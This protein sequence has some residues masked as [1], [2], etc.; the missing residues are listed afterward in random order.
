M[1]AAGR[2]RLCLVTAVFV[3]LLTVAPAVSAQPIDPI[4][5]YAADVDAEAGL[6]ARAPSTSGAGGHK[7]TTPDTGWDAIGSPLTQPSHYVDATVEVQAG[8]P[9][10]VWF[11]LRAA[12]DSKWNDSIWVQFDGASDEAGRALWP[13]GST[14]ALLV[15]LE[16]CIGCGTSGWGWQDNAS[17]TGQT[18]TVRFADSGRHRLRVQLREDGVDLDQIVL[19]S[20]R[21]ATA[22]PGA[23]RNDTTIVPKPAGGPGPPALTRQPYL[24]QVSDTGAVV[25]FTTS[26][27]GSAAV[28]FAAAGGAPQ[29]VPARSTMVP[30]TLSGGAAYH[31]H[32]ATLTGLSA[33]TTY[34]YDPLLGPLDLTAGND[35]FTTA[36][37]PGTGTVRFLAFGDSGV[38]SAA[39]RQ[40]AARMTT[41]PFDFAVHTGDVAYGVPEGHGAGGMPQ[42]QAWFFDIYRDLLR[43]RALFPSIGNH[44]DEAHHAEAY[45]S[46]FVL[47]ASPPDPRFP[48]HAERYYSFDYGAAH[49][50]VLDTELAFQD[51][52]RRDVQ[53]QWLVADLAASRQPWKIAVFHRSPYSAGGEHGSD[54]TVRSVLE[55][56]FVTGGVS[57]VLSGHEHDYERTLP[58]VRSGGGRGIV[59]LVTGGGG[60]PLYPASTAPWTAASAS[61]F[62]YVRGAVDACHIVLEAVDSDGRVFDGT[63]LSRCAAGTPFGGQPQV[64]PGIIEAE[65]FD[66]GGAGVAYGDAT[67]ANEG[68]RFRSDEA[69]DI[70]DSS[71][72]GGGFNVGWMFP[73]E[74]LTYTVMV[75]ESGTYDVFARVA[76]PGP[77]GTFTLTVDGVT[78]PGRFQVPQTGGWQQWQTV[79]GDRVALTPGV[80]H[81]RLDMRSAGVPGGAIGNINFLSL[82]LADR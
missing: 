5:I 33:A 61:V 74:W 34:V 63:T 7:L 47:P 10:H 27:S 9:Y 2:D 43:R 21:Y 18:A 79:H 67:T 36:P 72:A 39:Q 24:Q 56:I 81:L 66:G 14:S 32:E 57:L 20:A 25:V 1:P 73:G 15:N 42:L 17:W 13:I 19:S 48:D 80:H 52:G 8:V 31:Q 71:D 59:Y 70:E 11:R 40:L 53:A 64:V 46:A 58:Q 28:R 38:G 3:S 77:G 68:G 26:T 54:L 69:V 75:R 44:D 22:A 4:V 16:D 35:T 76:S 6:F 49:V 30:A 37:P 62:H 78:R 41:E 29:M 50:V 12:A 55:P 60:A 82:A 65:A 51:E 45:R 23:T